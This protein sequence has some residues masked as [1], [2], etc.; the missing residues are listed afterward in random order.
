M[1]TFK[2]HSAQSHLE[3]FHGIQIPQKDFE[4]MAIHGWDKIGN[5]RFALYIYKAPTVDCRLTLPCNVDIIEAVSSDVLDHVNPRN[6]NRYDYNNLPTESLIEAQKVNGNNLYVS[7]RLLTYNIEGDDLV[8]TQD[9]DNVNVLYKGVILDEEG[10]PYLNYKEVEA[11]ANYCAYVKTRKDG[12]IAKDKMT[13]EISNLLKAEWERSCQHARTP[14]LL[15]QNDWNDILEAQHSW[16][17]KKYN[18]SFKPVQ[19]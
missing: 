15:N 18:V 7:G 9:Y 10:L 1:E 5:K 13:I 19:R 8:F 11:I 2:F 3:T 16:N 17:R 12:M 4:E 14:I 6:T